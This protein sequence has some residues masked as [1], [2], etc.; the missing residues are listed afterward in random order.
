MVLSSK[1]FKPFFVTKPLDSV[2]HFKHIDLKSLS[3]TLQVIL[4]FSLQMLL[5]KIP[6]SLF[7]YFC[8]LFRLWTDICYFNGMFFCQLC[9]IIM[10][11]RSQEQFCSR[12]CHVFKMILFMVS[13]CNCHTEIQQPINISWSLFWWFEGSIHFIDLLLMNS[14]IPT[15]LFIDI[16]SLIVLDST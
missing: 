5:L 9:R 3:F 16:E 15:N 1:I 14:S 6:V 4:S 11:Q 10:I 13:W 7:I 2:R 8:F 12:S